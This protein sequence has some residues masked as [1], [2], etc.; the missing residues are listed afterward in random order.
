MGGRLLTADEVA[1]YLQVKR[2]WVYAET[3]A[4]RIPHV[5]LGRYV[6]YQ[7]DA[8]ELWIRQRA[9]GGDTAHRAS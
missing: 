6:R 8:V 3:R 2:S 9:A 1:A 4:N 7:V 5:R